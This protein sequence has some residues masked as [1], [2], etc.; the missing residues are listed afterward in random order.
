[1]AEDVQSALDE[2]VPALKDLQDRQVFTATEIH[3]IV[4]RRRNSEFETRRRY[5]PQKADF[6]RYI[7]AEVDLES[8]R[9]LR[10]KKLLRLQQD[11]QLPTKREEGGSSKEK[12]GD[13]H[14]LSH[15]HQLWKR[16]LQK[17]GKSDV[18]LYLQYAEFCKEINAHVPLSRILAE[19]LQLFPH[20][21]GLWAEAASH[22]F[23]VLGSIQNSRVL[24]QRG[25]RLL[26]QK[27]Q[28]LWLQLFCL[29]MHF[30]ERMKARRTILEGGADIERNE[31]NEEDT[32]NDSGN[33]VKDPHHVARMVYR[34]AVAAIPNEVAFRLKFWDQCRLFSDTASLQRDI[35]NSIRTDLCKDNPEAWMA[36][37]LYQW[38]QKSKGKENGKLKHKE[39]EELRDS[40]DQ[41]NDG[42]EPAPRND[43][44]HESETE[45][46]VRGG[47]EMKGPA[48][49][50]R[51]VGDVS[52]DA[53]QEAMSVLDVLRQAT[54]TLPTNEMYLKAV[55]MI[56]RYIASLQEEGDEDEEYEDPDISAGIYMLETLFKEAEQSKLF[57]SELVMEHALLLSRLNRKDEAALCLKRF[58]DARP[59]EDALKVW[60]HL[61]EISESGPVAVLKSALEKTDMSHPTY[62]ELL[63]HLFGAKIQAKDGAD[64]FSLFEKISLLTPGFCPLNE[65]EDPIFG[66]RHALDACLQFLRYLNEKNDIVQARKVYKN[67]LVESSLGSIF[68]TSFDDESLI[69]LVEEAVKIETFSSEYTEKKNGAPPPNRKNLE[70]LYDDAS[71]LFGDSEVGRRYQ[72]R[73]REEMLG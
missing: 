35:V 2:M 69:A 71:K 12:I 36:W 38:E 52:E 67:V 37:A 56:T 63:L 62:Y 65:I 51:R 68:S 10:T 30:M 28:E 32:E 45:T 18:A 24:L 42:D 50:K 34:S 23:F 15:I 8:L 58:A 9:K 44:E 21:E 48:H 64:L 17:F 47:N 20:N 5:N 29:E 41:G 11:E 4:D 49:K 16:T 40:D 73:K 22:E 46:R 19:A 57:S 53:G 26:Q 61:A 6:L 39:E 13:V 33:A 70:R 3:Q 66:V 59:T 54:Q 1:M 31:E 25:I 72:E 60:I 27:S 55:R 14:I 7:Q 43:I